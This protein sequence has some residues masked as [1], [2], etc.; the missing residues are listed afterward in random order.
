MRPLVF[1]VPLVIMAVGAS[2]MGT[3]AIVT[4]DAGAVRVS[5]MEKK[6]HGTN[7]HLLV[8][9]VLVPAALDL[10]PSHDLNL[11][12]RDTRQWLPAAKAA[13]RELDRCPDA[14]LVQVTSP[15]E[16]VNIS[17]RGNSIYI[18]VDDT[19]ETVHVSFP[20]PVARKVVEKF[21]ESNPGPPV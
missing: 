12:D 15:G 10:V 11:H 18:D 20:V 9:A 16:N 13:L 3:A 7:F 1:K 14:A 17:K 2:I 4:Y 8:P 6:S 21:E 19:N 5:V